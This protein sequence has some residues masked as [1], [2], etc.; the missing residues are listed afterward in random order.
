MNI[1]KIGVEDCQNG[2]QRIDE[3]FNYWL[4]FVLG[5]HSACADQNALTAKERQ[6]IGGY[7]L[8]AEGKKKFLEESKLG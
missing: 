3:K 6:L 1:L 5:L 2:A 4:N 8:I 7:E